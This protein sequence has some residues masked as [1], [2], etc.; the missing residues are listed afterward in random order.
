MK[1]L[2]FLLLALGLA[3]TAFSS[4]AQAPASP[5]SERPNDPGERT[6]VAAVEPVVFKEMRAE[7]VRLYTEIQGQGHD[8]R[9]SWLRRW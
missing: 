9:E 8:W 3:G 5:R 7:M 4:S 1:R 6:D 2:H